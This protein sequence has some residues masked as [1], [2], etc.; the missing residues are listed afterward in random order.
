MF[1][2]PRRIDLDMLLLTVGFTAPRPARSAGAIHV[3][4]AAAC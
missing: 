1:N 2:A 4:R 3:E